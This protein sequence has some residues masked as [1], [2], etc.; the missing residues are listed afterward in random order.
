[1]C[2]PFRFTERICPFGRMCAD[3][4]PLSDTCLPGGVCEARA[5]TPADPFAAPPFAFKPP[6]ALALARLP[7][8]PPA[9]AVPGRLFVAPAR[10]FVAPAR[11]FAAAG[12]L[13]AAPARLLVP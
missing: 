7:G 3:P 6:P 2:I 4:P 9:P 12:R 10:L 1:M 8:R 13:F 5:F 11:L